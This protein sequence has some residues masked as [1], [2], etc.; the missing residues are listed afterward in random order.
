MKNIIARLR[1][2]YGGMLK[3]LTKSNPKIEFAF[4]ES[5]HATSTSPWHIRKLTDKGLKLSGGADTKAL[6]GLEVCWDLGVEIDPLYLEQPDCCD[7]C[8]SEFEIIKN[9]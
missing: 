6:C 9:D 2:K 8:V 7:K 4:C 1:K 3:N 5:V